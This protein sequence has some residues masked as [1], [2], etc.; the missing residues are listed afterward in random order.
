[1]TKII[2]N[3]LTLFTSFM[4]LRRLLAL[5]LILF[6][7]YSIPSSPLFQTGLNLG[8]NLA[9]G[10]TPKKQVKKKKTTKKRAKKRA[11][12]KGKKKAGKSRLITMNFNNV[13]IS[14]FLSAMSR[15]FKIAYVWDEKDIKGKITLVS[16]RK[17]KRNDA[18]KIFGTVLALHGYTTI[19]KTGSPVVQ[20]VPIKGA[21]RMPNPTRTGAPRVRGNDFVT[22]IIPLKY[23]DP[24]QV[25]AALTPLINPSAALAVYAPANLLMLSD[26]EESIRRVLSV[27]KQ[28][29]VAGGDSEFRIIALQNA[30]AKKLAPLITSLFG[31]SGARKRPPVRGRPPVAGSAGSGPTKI[32]AEER[33]NSLIIIADPGTMAQLSKLIARL[34]IPSNIPDT[35]IKVYRLEHAD[36]EEMVKI[37]STFQRTAGKG[38]MKGRRVPTGSKIPDVT[39]TADKPTNSLIVFGTPDTITTMDD[40]VRQLDIRRPQVF[41][42]AL[43]ME[44]T[45]EKSL[46]LGINWQTSSPSGD[47]VTGAGFPGST[48]QNLAQTIAGGAG[49]VMGIVGNEITFQGQSFVS[50]SAFLRAIRQDQDINIL[51]NP[52]ILTL[53]NEEA[54]INVSQVIPVTAKVLRDASNATTTEF[55]FKDIGIILKLTPQIT[56][57]KHVRLTISQESSSVAAKETT[58]GSDQQA[59]TTLKR[60][61]NTKVLVANN[62]TIAIGGLIQ[63]QAVKNDTKVP[64]LGD[65]PVLGW[66]FKSR[67]E[68]VRK[69]NLIV[70]IRPRIVTSQKDL[71]AISRDVNTRFQKA[72]KPGAKIEKILTKALDLVPAGAEKT[73]KGG[74]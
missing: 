33:T 13:D 15:A 70:F 56:G 48:P 2:W 25:K 66:F 21:A 20:V 55:E 44:M 63:D 71:E 30:S 19:R 14:T 37:L 23:A 41:V 40:L 62:T 68:Q 69:T 47:S 28:L 3:P 17:F 51:A 54:E 42:E 67:S 57:D 61:I 6:F 9:Q 39:I 29:D 58:T 36:A 27:V 10:Q 60:T 26:S 31:K 74:K 72:R 32:V 11:T 73:K 1:M 8:V 18:L 52:Q 22:Q 4:R 49:S 50:F 59:I 46:Q 64:C 12:K 53:N 16:P 38:T 45:L 34:D 5:F 24:N 65:I 43:I 35:G 7:S